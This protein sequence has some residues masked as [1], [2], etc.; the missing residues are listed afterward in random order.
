MYE[1]GAGSFMAD[2]PF[3][4]KYGPPNLPTG[5]GLMYLES[6][7]APTVDFWVISAYKMVG[8]DVDPG[9]VPNLIIF[10]H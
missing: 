5:Q 9:V 1:T 7:M 3:A 2:L 8:M 4:G 6:T 10:E